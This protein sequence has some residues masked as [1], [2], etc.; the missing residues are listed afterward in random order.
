L[1]IDSAITKANNVAKALFPPLLAFYA[2]RE[3][4]FA[5]IIGVNYDKGEQAVNTAFNE[6]MAEFLA[7]IEQIAKGE[8]GPGQRYELFTQVEELQAHSK[9]ETQ[10]SAT[11]ARASIKKMSEEQVKKI[12][13]KDT[14]TAK[15]KKQQR[16]LASEK[17]VILFSD[18]IVLAAEAAG[19][20]HLPQTQLTQII[21][22]VLQ[23][24]SINPA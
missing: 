18:R 14:I 2:A 20:K 12:G 7:D 19:V 9:K 6:R 10:K 16:E 5:D 4:E 24:K 13:G 22:A 21:N 8:M 3:A 11:K 23:G 1:D 15:A 17:Y